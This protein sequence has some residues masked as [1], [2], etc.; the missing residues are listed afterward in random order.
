[1]EA[2]FHHLLKAIPTHF[3]ETKEGRQP[4]KPAAHSCSSSSGFSPLTAKVILPIIT[5]KIVEMK[6]SSKVTLLKLVRSLH[7][8]MYSSFFG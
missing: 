5:V 2:V 4:H 1:M 7:T 8:V 6:F 3:A